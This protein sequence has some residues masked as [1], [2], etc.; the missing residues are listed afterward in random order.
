MYFALYQ[1]LIGDNGAKHYEELFKPEFF[2]LV[3]VDECHRGSA[4]EDSQ[5]RTI[6]EYF[7]DATQIGMTATPKETQYISNIDHGTDY[8]IHGRLCQ[9][10]KDGLYTDYDYERYP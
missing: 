2:D 10:R 9:K 7:K 6:L 8:I 5:W 1:Q 4:A 3:I